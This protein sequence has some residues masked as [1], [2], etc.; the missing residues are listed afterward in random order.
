MKDKYKEAIIRDIILKTI[1]VIITC[2]SI[3]AIIIVWKY[4]NKKI[5]QIRGTAIE[6]YITSIPIVC[7]IL[8]IWRETVLSNEQKSI[9]TVFSFMW[10]AFP[11][12]IVGEIILNKAIKINA[13]L[14][15]YEIW[16]YLTPIVSVISALIYGYKKCY[17]KENIDF[18]QIS[19]CAVIF[20]G[21]YLFFITIYYNAFSAISAKK[22]LLDIASAF[23][24]FSLVIISGEKVWIFW[25]NNE[26]IRMFGKS[27][28]VINKN[29]KR[30]GNKIP[31]NL[32][33]WKKVFIFWIRMPLV[34]ATIDREYDENDKSTN[35]KIYTDWII[36][37]EKSFKKICDDNKCTI[38]KLAEC[39]WNINS[40][41]TIKN[42]TRGKNDV[43][44]RIS[45]KMKHISYGKIN[46][47]VKELIGVLYEEAK[48]ELDEKEKIVTPWKKLI[49]K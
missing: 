43:A 37:H 16:I 49:E 6:M 33:D 15:Y 23:V 29:V 20:C 22:S 11:F 32:V 12:G 45:K 4:Y 24:A 13:A 14:L 2:L 30:I 42:E 31:K 34:L 48:I 5:G 36:A 21:T 46:I 8:F 9:C 41:L 1:L 3:G 39:L 25:I 27:A 35:K 19:N 17:E 38:Y 7:S 28:F 44:L 10:I 40:S 47:S 18:K 26:E